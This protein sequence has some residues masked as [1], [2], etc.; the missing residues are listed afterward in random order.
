MRDSHGTTLA[1]AV[2]VA[3]AVLA[4]FVLTGN[5]AAGSTRMVRDIANGPTS[6]DP[7]FLTPYKGQLFFTASTPEHGEELWRSN[8]TK[9]GTR[10]VKDI[11]P[12]PASGGA[13]GPTVVNGILYFTAWTEE[14]G[15]E[16][17]RSDGTTNGTRLLQRHPSGAGRL[18]ATSAHAS[19]KATVLLS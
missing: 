15:L 17:W 5:V 9:T 3:V 18:M 13:V 16:L 8:G 14:Y 19:G 2:A 12:G 7:N 6:S 11:A 4:A 10:L 1:V